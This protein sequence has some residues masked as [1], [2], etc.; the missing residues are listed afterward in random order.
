MPSNN[1]TNKRENFSRRMT[2]GINTLY[3]ISVIMLVMVCLY[4]L[5][6]SGIV[7]AINMFLVLI[8]LGITTVITFFVAMIFAYI[9]G[10]MIDISKNI[11]NNWR[12]RNE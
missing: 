3:Y 1:N 7:L 8:G 10:T 4:M 12:N 6:N 11:Y 5:S 2:V 9:V